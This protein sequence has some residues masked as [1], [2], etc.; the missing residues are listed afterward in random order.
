MAPP[1]F[2]SDPSDSPEGLGKARRAWDAYSR[3]VTVPM[4]PVAKAWARRATADVIGFW[5]LWH[6]F[7]GFE[8]L[9]Q[10]Y[11]M[12]KSTIWRKV[13]KFRMAFNAHPDEFVIP[14]IT[15]DTESF[16]AAAIENSKRIKKTE[17]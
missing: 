3:A 7:G 8:G 2:R 5:V 14:G 1:D 9:E 17:A 12:H 10:N 6:T 16:W 11:G 13:A 4:Q 15:L